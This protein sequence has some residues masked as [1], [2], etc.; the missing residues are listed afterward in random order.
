M[1]LLNAGSAPH[2]GSFY[3]ASSVGHTASITAGIFFSDDLNPDVTPYHCE[4]VSTKS[5][6]NREFR[7]VICLFNSYSLALTIPLIAIVGQQRMPLRVWYSKPITTKNWVTTSYQWADVIC[8]QASATVGAYSSS[9]NVASQGC[10]S[11][12][13]SD[14]CLIWWC[15]DIAFNLCT[16]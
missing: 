5:S 10:E 6:P 3:T 11:S 16:T 2:S 12:F 13:E 4:L 9:D 15:G 14:W 7:Y 8:R 1:Y